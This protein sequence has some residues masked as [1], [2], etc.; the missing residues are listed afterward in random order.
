V[1][2]HGTLVAASAKSKRSQLLYTRNDGHLARVAWQLMYS[3]LAPMGKV[4]VPDCCVLGW[5]RTDGFIKHARVE[6]G[7]VGAQLR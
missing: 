2:L 4:G 7:V 3:L 6:H 1:A 5:S